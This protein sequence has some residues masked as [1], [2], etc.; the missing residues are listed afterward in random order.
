MGQ[1]REQLVSPPQLGAAAA[2]R[3]VPT[4]SARWISPPLLFMLPLLLPLRLLPGAWR[5]ISSP[6]CCRQQD[7]V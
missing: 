4:T 6:C 2:G 5:N 1:K 7:G 3:D